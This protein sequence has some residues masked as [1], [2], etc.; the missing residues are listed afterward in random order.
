MLKF[1]DELSREYAAMASQLLLAVPA[2]SGG[3]GGGLVWVDRA[4]VEQPD[5]LA[6]RNS[7]S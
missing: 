5:E 4:Q 3:A 7:Y 6:T 2:I 1:N